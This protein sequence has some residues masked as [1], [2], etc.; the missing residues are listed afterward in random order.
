MRIVLATVPTPMLLRIILYLG[1]FTREVCAMEATWTA[2]SAVSAG[3]VCI[4]AMKSS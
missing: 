3:A 1:L 2:A 4:M